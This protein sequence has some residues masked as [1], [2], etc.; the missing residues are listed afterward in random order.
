MTQKMLDWFPKPYTNGIIAKNSKE[1][2]SAV[3]N[4]L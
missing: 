1:I 2:S 4:Q 3:L